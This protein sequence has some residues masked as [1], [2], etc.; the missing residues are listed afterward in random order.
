MTEQLAADHQID[1]IYRRSM[2]LLLFALSINRLVVFVAMHSAAFMSTVESFAV[3]G[4]KSPMQSTKTQH[5]CSSSRTS[6]HT[7][8][9][10]RPSGAVCDGLSAPHNMSVGLYHGRPKWKLTAEIWKKI[11]NSTAV[12]AQFVAIGLLYSQ[13]FMPTIAFTVDPHQIVTVR[14]MAGPRRMGEFS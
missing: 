13:N 11:A 7:Q 8:P 9:R 4:T 14:W 6:Q 3:Y 2:L 10:G 1:A 12:T 5:M